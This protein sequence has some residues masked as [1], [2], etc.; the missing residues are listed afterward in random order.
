MIRASL[1]FLLTYA[2]ITGRRTG[3]IRIG[4]PAGVVLGSVLMVMAG[5]LT[6]DQAYSA[7]NW[8]TI[9]LLLGMMILI[10]HLA[11]ANFFLIISEKISARNFST[12]SLLALVVFGLGTLAAF[13]V[14]DIVC[15]FFTPVLI[16]M[17]RKRNLPPLP[18]LLALATSTN[19]GG[20]MATTGTP[21]NMIIGHLSGISYSRYFAFMAPVGLVCLGINFLTLL[22]IY[23]R[24]LEQP[25][26]PETPDTPTTDN[27]TRPKK[28]F[29]RSVSIMTLVI[30]CFFFFD[31]IAW[32][33]ISGAAFL[34]LFVNQDEDSLLR[35]LDWNLLLFFV[36]LFVV[37]GGLRES[38][39]ID[40]LILH[41]LGWVHD[42]TAGTWLFGFFSVVGSN[43]FANVPFV[44]VIAET[45]K[46]M[47]DPGFFWLILAF[48]ST[49]AGN[50]TII[51]AVANIIVI[52]RAR[53]VR[54]VSFLDF[55]KF[56]IPSTL[57]CFVAGM[58][59]L[60]LYRFAGWL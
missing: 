34:L 1:I 57:L 41:V 38:G 11:E 30:A 21:Q 15:I 46:T 8:D 13:F 9:L 19:I 3:L 31:N 56:G 42:S 26:P 37:V 52:E 59:I 25:A 5:I 50:L 39:A 29:H 10:E 48:S 22:A 2:I 23:R 49:I 12:V 55:M 17:I 14:N 43:L 60:T 44:L 36:G 18:F 47:A 45:I 4:R 32:V 28:G 20:V 7:V 24:D 58:G 53:D 54:H 16:L 27:K 40:F 35:K 51:G 33:S 6:P